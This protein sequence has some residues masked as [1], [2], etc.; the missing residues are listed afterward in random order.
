MQEQLQRVHLR[1]VQDLAVRRLAIRP[2]C[3]RYLRVTASVNSDFFP[4][5]SLN[6]PKAAISRKT[7]DSNQLHLAPIPILE[8]LDRQVRVG[9]TP[10]TQSHLFE[11]PIFQQQGHRIAQ[12]LSGQQPISREALR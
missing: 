5:L 6:A 11:I 9:D 8:M 4:F 1:S 7:R 12:V 10:A 2:Y 3:N